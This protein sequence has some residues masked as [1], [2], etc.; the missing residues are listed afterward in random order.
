MIIPPKIYTL[1]T[2]VADD[3]GLGSVG[4]ATK[5]GFT[6]A[7]FGAKAPPLPTD[8]SPVVA[9]LR[10]I[11]SSIRKVQSAGPA[12]RVQLGAELASL[13]ADLPDI[14]LQII[15]Y[16]LANHLP[17]M[18]PVFVDRL[19]QHHPARCS[20]HCHDHREVFTLGAAR[21]SR[22][23]RAGLQLGPSGLEATSGTRQPAPTRAHGSDL[24]GSALVVRGNPSG[25]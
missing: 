11:R 19:R 12:L 24:I 23:R 6:T 16:I 4:S 9:L 22:R 18:V 7:S 10:T 5:A 21:P 25:R 15:E 20:S 1:A 3:L 14:E 2:S 13:E 8:F 17:G